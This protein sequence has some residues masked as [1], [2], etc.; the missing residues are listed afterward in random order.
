MTTASPNITLTSGAVSLM[1]ASPIL[2][3]GTTLQVL[4]ILPI[5]LNTATDA[6]MAVLSDG[7]HWTTATLNGQA[8]DAYLG[9]QYGVQSIVVIENYAR[10]IMAKGQ[11]ASKK[12]VP[13]QFKA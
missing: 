1:I 8:L 2:L 9:G 4:D 10:S 7:K 5:A 12:A 11:R 6:Y 3:L 13:L